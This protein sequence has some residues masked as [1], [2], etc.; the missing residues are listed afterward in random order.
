M[1]ETVKAAVAA[2]N[3]KLDGEG[4]AGVAKFV[5]EGKGAIIVDETGARA[6]AEAGELPADVTLTADTETFRA[7]IEGEKNPTTAYMTG[8]LQM[9][10]DMGAA[11]RLAKTLAG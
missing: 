5:I 3:K 6:A 10:G 4:F 2:L 11:M 9:D 7:I 1:S 8:A